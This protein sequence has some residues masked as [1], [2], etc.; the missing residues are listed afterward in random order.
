GV[1]EPMQ[2]TV[3]VDPVQAVIGRLHEAVERH[4]HRV[5][6]SGHPCPQAQ[7]GLP[8]PSSLKGASAWTYAPAL[9][10]AIGPSAV[11]CGLS[12]SAAAPMATA[13]VAM[14]WARGKRLITTFDS[15]MEIA[16]PRTRSMGRSGT[17][18]RIC[19]PKMMPIPT[20]ATSDPAR[21]CHRKRSSPWT[22]A[23]RKV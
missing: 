20:S 23:R 18:S 9:A 19:S 2:L 14:G 6:E 7:P 22:T 21:L 17:E 1:D 10:G 5:D 8:C 16:P 4:H 13:L 11:A 15:A 3:D 12:R